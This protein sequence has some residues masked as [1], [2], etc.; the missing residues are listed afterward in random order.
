ML[1]IFLIGLA[2]VGVVQTVVTRSLPPAQRAAQDFLTFFARYQEQALVQGQT[3]GILLDPPNYYVM[4]RR[5]GQ[6]RPMVS[7]RHASRETLP[8]TIQMR[9]QQ[10][11]DIWRQEYALELQRRRLTL[12]DIELELRREAQRHIPQIIF[13]PFEPVTPFT[14]RFYSGEVAACWAVTM[15]PAGGLSLTDCALEEG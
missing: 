1:V 10:G 4:Q 13:S 15:D 6:W 8:T 2:S 9:L 5:Q 7:I 3:I 11:R 12:Q 14:L